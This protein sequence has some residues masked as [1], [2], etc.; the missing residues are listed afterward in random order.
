MTR[1]DAEV[2]ERKLGNKFVT[3]TFKAHETGQLLADRRTQPSLTWANTQKY[4]DRRKRRSGFRSVDGVHAAIASFEIHIPQSHS[5]KE[6]RA[7]LRPIVEGLRNRF[8]VSVAEVDHQD[9]WQRSVIGVAVV[10]NEHSHVV[11]VL[12]EVERFIDIAADAD[13]CSVDVHW[14]DEG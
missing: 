14:F 5:L 9:T 3:G 7:V 11:A 13:L 12:E 1:S 6:K 4:L 10:A 8:H 2:C